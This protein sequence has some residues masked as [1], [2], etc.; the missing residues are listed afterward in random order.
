MFETM[1]EDVKIVGIT[2]DSR[3]VEPGFL[4]AALPGTKTEGTRFVPDA[5]KAGA[6]A[7]LGTEQLE[8]LEGATRVV[9]ENPRRA[10]ARIAAR[11][12]QA[13]PRVIAAVTGTN[14]K[15][16]VVG[17]A[18]Q[19]WEAS[20]ERAASLGTL[21]LE[22]PVASAKGATLTTPDPAQLHRL[23]AELAAN[24]I[25]HLAIEAS[26]HGLEQF[27]LDGVRL[28]VAVFTTLSRDHLDYHGSAEAYLAAKQRLFAELL[29]E[30]GA[31]VLNADDAAF[32]AFADLCAKRGL[33]TLTYG[34]GGEDFRLLESRPAGDG[35]EITCR[36]LDQRQTFHLPL[37]GAFQAKNVLAALGLV[38][39]AGGDVQAGLKALPEL[40][41]IAGR[42]EA[43]GRLANG[44]RVYVDYAHTPDALTHALAALRPYTKARLGVV[45]GCGGERDRGKRPEMGAIADALADVVFVTD[46]NPRHEDA[47]AIRREILIASRKG[48]EIAER[49]EAIAT[50]IAALQADDVLLI[51]GK[52]HETGQVVGDATRPFDDRETAKA[53][54]RTQ[55]GTA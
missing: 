23:L 20:G 54:I 25:D 36:L 21:G 42:M 48:R 5:L 30:G 44:A 49:G 4:F 46:D 10:F 37:V 9:T 35:Q 2:A 24:Q 29:P 13:Q 31:A 51:A 27:R 53:A 18:R 38:H 15:S 43:V 40:G 45:F 52:G 50:A 19:I 16:S 32:N 8:T 34:E 12:Y 7:V 47:A 17:F 28:S 22:P 1:G 33:R 3:N 39:A 41:G 6:V 55:G 26:S 14:G 11:F